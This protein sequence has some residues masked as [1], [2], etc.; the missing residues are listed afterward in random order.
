MSNAGENKELDFQL[1]LE[2]APDLYLILKSD[3]PRFTIVGVNQAYLNATMTLREEILNK[4]LFEVFPDNPDDDKADAALLVKMKE[5]HTG[6]LLSEPE[7]NTFV[8]KLE[9]ASGK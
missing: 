7:V 6:N 2:S 4:G 3:A 5:N 1:I 9:K 8:S